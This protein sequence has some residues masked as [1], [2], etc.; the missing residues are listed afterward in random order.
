MTKDI[1]TFVT[2][3]QK[4][5]LQFPLQL[6]QTGICTIHPQCYSI[7]N[8]GHLEFCLRLNSDEE[9]AEDEL[10]GVKYIYKI[11]HLFIKRPNVH[12]IY[13]VRGV[14]NALYMIYPTETIPYFAGFNMLPEQPGIEFSMTDELEQLYRQ[15]LLLLPSSGEKK[16]ADRFD[17][18]AFSILHEIFLQKYNKM[19]PVT[20]E[21][22]TMHE[23]N[24]FIQMNFRNPDVLALAVSN[25]GYSYRTFLR[26]WKELFKC[27][28][29]AFIEKLRMDEAVRLLQNHNFMI[30]E[31]SSLTGFTYSGN[32]IQAFKRRF[33]I[34]P[35]AW[36]KQYNF[37]NN[38][39]FFNTHNK[40]PE[41]Q[42]K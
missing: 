30:K 28:P 21:I 31:I 16:S 9:Y 35:D 20:P 8:H 40:N 11:P 23:I 6:I 36:R 4:R 41:P 24:S 33:G 25:S 22:N 7:P 29:G 17:M 2:L 1:Y 37:S 19:F 13:E 12:H 38:S 34:S 42:E 5:L 27:T 14:R 3:E 10:D 39:F 18:L 26:R 32:F 15:Y